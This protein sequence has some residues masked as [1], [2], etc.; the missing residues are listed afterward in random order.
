VSVPTALITGISGQDGSYLAEL[1]SDQGYRVVGTTRSARAPNVLELRKRVNA[2]EIVEED[3][4][5][6]RR[7]ESLL[8]HVEPAEVYNLAAR[9][10]STDLFAE[11][12]SVGDVNGLAVVRLLEAIRVVDPRIRFLQALSSEIFAG[13]QGAPLSEASSLHPANTY[14]AAKVFAYWTVRVYREQHGLHASSAILFNHESPRRGH[15]FVS[16]KISRAVALIRAGR[17]EKLALGSLGSQRDWSFAG[18]FVRAM[19]LIVAHPEPG[20]YVLASGIAHSVRD[21]CEI[22]FRHAGLDYRDYVAEASEYS[23]A[24]EVATRVGNPSKATTTLGWKPRVSFRGLVEMMVDHDIKVA[25]REIDYAR[26]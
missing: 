22:A 9:A 19:Q 18:D 11:P 5:E 6:Q 1:L 25:A 24:H 4:L 17:Q 20:D 10:S 2:L 15:Q 26:N 7:L 21:F 23:R 8:A 14:A 3:L 12:V 16:R 13:Q